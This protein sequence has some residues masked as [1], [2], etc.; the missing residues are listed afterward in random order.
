MLSTFQ[1]NV[2]H[3]IET[4]LLVFSVNQLSVL[5]IMKNIDF[6]CVNACYR[7]NLCKCGLN[8]IP[9]HKNEVFHLLEKSLI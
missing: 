3:H 9:L 5:Y 8:V 7:K 2:S 4:S 1:V 6:K